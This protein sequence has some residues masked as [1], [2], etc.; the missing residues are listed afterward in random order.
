MRNHLSS[1]TL[2]LAAIVWPMAIYGFE[3]P[4]APIQYLAQISAPPSA[5]GCKRGKGAQWIDE[6]YRDVKWIAVPN[7][8]TFVGGYDE[9]FTWIGSNTINRKGEVIGLDVV[10]QGIYMRLN[11]NCKSKLYAIV[12]GSDT[13]VDPN[14]YYQANDNVSQTLGYA[15]KL[16]K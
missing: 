4:T 9:G 2:S 13:Y 15:C 10:Y 11:A 14:K 6:C 12:A 8:R 7:S 5:G 16:S 1:Y 3:T